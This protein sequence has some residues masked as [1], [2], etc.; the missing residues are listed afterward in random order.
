MNNTI[1]LKTKKKNGNKREE[2]LI[3]KNPLQDR[4]TSRRDRR[5]TN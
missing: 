5:A 4:I 1:R 3:Y 2:E